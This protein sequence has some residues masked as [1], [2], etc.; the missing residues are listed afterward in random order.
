[1]VSSA[2]KSFKPAHI[3]GET[4]AT[5]SRRCG[6]EKSYACVSLRL[7]SLKPAIDTPFMLPTVASG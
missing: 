1:M 3:L 4:W 2:M 7:G 5:Q 6:A